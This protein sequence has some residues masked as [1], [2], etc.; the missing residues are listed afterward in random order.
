MPGDVL[1]D[2][3]SCCCKRAKPFS[4]ETARQLSSLNSCARSG[5]SRAESPRIEAPPR[6]TVNPGEG[7]AV[8]AAAA[9][10]LDLKS[11]RS[12]SRAC[13]G[14][15]PSAA[16]PLAPDRLEDTESSSHAPSS[17]SSSSVSS[18]PTSCSQRAEERQ[19]QRVTSQ[20]GASA[21]EEAL[22]TQAKVDEQHRGSERVQS[23]LSSDEKKTP[24]QGEQL[25][26]CH[27]AAREQQGPAASAAAPESEEGEKK[28][29]AEAV[30]SAEGEKPATTEAS[31]CKEGGQRQAAES[32]DAAEEQAEATE[33]A[34]P[35]AATPGSPKSE[36]P[37][38]ATIASAESGAADALPA[39]EASP[40]E[41]REQLR[42]KDDSTTCASPESLLR[43]DSKALEIPD[44][45]NE[46][47]QTGAKQ[48]PVDQ[49]AA[50]K[51]EARAEYPVKA[52][53]EGG[54]NGDQDSAAEKQ[55]SPP[56]APPADDSP[57][58][59]TGG[60]KDAQKNGRLDPESASADAKETDETKQVREEASPEADAVAAREAAEQEETAA[61]TENGKAQSKRGGHKGR[62]ASRRGRN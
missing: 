21:L 41:P 32:S 5:A 48:S 37:R 30:D 2:L 51:R 12:L 49:A 54:A 45:Q 36:T 57:A 23:S 6:S 39:L 19:A 52:S 25:A 34:E 16:E 46:A 53:A 13:S 17:A 31:D 28:E 50:T 56:S 42:P 15:A 55:P 22:R 27:K 4:A 44:E 24:P 47:K 59:S 3:L 43:A 33:T 11:A 18:P 38:I 7:S 58:A 8:A 62:R 35:P 61:P 29:T 40:E 14:R 1:V 9:Q 20:R 26:D 60:E 10:P